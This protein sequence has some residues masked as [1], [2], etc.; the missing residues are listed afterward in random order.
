MKKTTDCRIKRYVKNC[1][2][3]AFVLGLSLALSG[4]D[5]MQINSGKP[6]VTDKVTDDGTAVNAGKAKP[7]TQR[8]ITV[9]FPNKTG[10]KLLPAKRKIKGE[11]PVEEMVSLILEGPDETER[12]DG[13]VR[14]FPKGVKL[15]GVAVRDKVAR[16]DFSAEL[17]KEFQGGSTGEIMLASSLV[18]TLTKCPEIEKVQ[19][20]VEGK[21]IGSLS[22]HLDFS[23]PMEEFKDY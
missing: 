6:A 3:L 16:V 18:N 22:G 12:A 21:E 23:E 14:P 17:T 4:C 7:E 15:L 11:A 13:M 1:L 20:L 5:D 19:V 10:E 2:V 8:K 9:Y